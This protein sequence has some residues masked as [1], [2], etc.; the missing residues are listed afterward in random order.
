[1]TL[2]KPVDTTGADG[3]VTQT[4]QTF[5]EVWAGKIPVGTRESMFAND[6]MSTSEQVEISIRRKACPDL[7]PAYRFVYGSLI[8]EIAQVVLDDQREQSWRCLCQRRAL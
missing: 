8:Y 4:W 6:S 2:Q 1:M 5:A 7:T 3:V